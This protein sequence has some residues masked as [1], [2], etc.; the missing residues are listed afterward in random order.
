MDL[1]FRAVGFWDL[2]SGGALAYSGVSISRGQQV[3]MLS[4]GS[5][6]TRH[7]AGVLCLRRFG[8]RASGPNNG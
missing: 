8:L 1:G 2:A 5:Q 6:G 4:N 3:Q 7:L